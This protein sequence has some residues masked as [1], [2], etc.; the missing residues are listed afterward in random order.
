MSAALGPR[1]AQ[2]TDAELDTPSPRK[3]PIADASVLGAIGFL[4][5]H[6]AYHIGQLALVRKA[7]GLGGLAG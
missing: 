6:E 2:L 4:A 5:C 7:L 1:L 3:L